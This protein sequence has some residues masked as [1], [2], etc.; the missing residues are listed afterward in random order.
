VKLRWTL[1][2]VAVAL[3]L[4][5][6]LQYVE[7]PKGDRAKESEARA[8]KLAPIEA[9]AVR[10]LELPLKDGGTAR[11]V[12]DGEDAWKLEAPLAWGAD[13]G[14]V[15]GIVSALADLS[16]ES[17]VKEIPADLA[18][19]GFGEPAKVVRVTL[20]EGE[21]I[22]LRLGGKAPI[23]T[24]RYV[25]REGAERR[26][27]SV[28]DASLFSLEPT[29]L[30]LRDKE[31]VRLDSEAIDSLR[32]TAGGKLVVAAKREPAEPGDAGAEPDWELAEPIADRADAPRIRHLLQDL[33]YLRATGFRDG[34]IDE[35]ATGL[36]S[37][38]A[39][40]E[41]RA[42]EK[43][44]RVAFGR[45]GGK[46]FARLEG[47][48]VVFEVPD[49]ILAD[50]PRDL[51]A[52]RFKQVAALPTDRATRLALYLPRDSAQFAFA[53]K[54]NEWVPEASDVS[55]DTYKLEDVLYALRN[56]EATAL[57]EGGPEPAKL[58][59]EPPRVRVELTDT[60]G[61][62]LGWVELGDQTD[63]GI[64][65]RSSEGDRLWRV[66]PEVGQDIPLSIDAWNAHW[67]KK[68]ATDAPAEAEPAPEPAARVE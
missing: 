35:K 57:V 13:D 55:V 47:Q 14:S 18:P 32:V 15:D 40:V 7:L 1:V 10:A 68:P 49:R 34:A 48:P 2:L 33:S 50:L 62:S 46:V 66:A 25:L 16:V 58:G 28:A 27:A 23:G 9:A 3:G 24:T 54:E 42:G 30:A 26:L 59:L 31:I 61:K 56:L 38:E 60:D 52:Y 51:F 21:P 44:E 67:V 64:A 37:P 53:K 17:E 22:E 8:K 5:L 45:G 36:A 65:A 39:E 41:L 20:A 11:V 29:L 4:L 19:F 6:Y 12:R 43:V 63:A